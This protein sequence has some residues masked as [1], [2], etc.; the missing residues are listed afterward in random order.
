MYAISKHFQEMQ[1]I[2]DYSILFKQLPA[3]SYIGNFHCYNKG[4]IN[5]PVHTQTF[6]HEDHINS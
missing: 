2:Y 4:T 1:N 5:I 6:L 3:D